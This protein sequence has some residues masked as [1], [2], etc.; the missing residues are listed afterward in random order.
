MRSMA[1]ASVD[2]VV[3]DP[4]AGIAFMGKA[5]DHDKGG[6]DAWIGWLTEVMGECL[7]VLKPGG[8]ALVWA[9]PRPATGP[10]WRWRTQASR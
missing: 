9:I 7:R 8:H 10:A 1:D 6:R 4:P 5:W 3:S 2:A